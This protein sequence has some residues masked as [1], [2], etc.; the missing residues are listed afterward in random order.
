MNPTTT[1]SP[2][3]VPLSPGALP[4]APTPWFLLAAGAACGCTTRGVN[5]S[6]R[7]LPPCDCSFRSLLPQSPSQRSA[8]SGWENTLLVCIRPHGTPQCSGGAAGRRMSC[9]RPR[10]LLRVVSSC[11]PKMWEDGEWRP[12]PDS[13]KA[14]VGEKKRGLG[15]AAKLELKPLGSWG[16]V[17]RWGHQGPGVEVEGSEGCKLSPRERGLSPVP[18]GFGISFLLS[19]VPRTEIT[20]EVSLVYLQP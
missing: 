14:V 19:A 1:S 2:R 13:N 9:C 20:Q 4:T 12:K 15:A 8:E 18:S 5:A 10:A 3:P 17:P 16:V 11:P 7:S 6:P